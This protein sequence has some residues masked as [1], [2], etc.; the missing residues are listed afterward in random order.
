M[1]CSGLDV[2]MY[3]QSTPYCMYQR[4]RKSRMRQV[5]ALKPTLDPTQSYHAPISI[6]I[7]YRFQMVQK[8]LEQLLLDTGLRCAARQPGR[9]FH[10]GGW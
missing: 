2:C 3:I 7:A 8:F 1:F 6:L 9:H 5:D 10:F 4:H